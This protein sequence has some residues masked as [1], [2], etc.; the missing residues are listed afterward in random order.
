MRKNLII[1]MNLK[2]KL[3]GYVIYLHHQS[4]K[5]ALFSSTF[6]QDDEPV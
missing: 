2:N 5:Y 6:N 3:K 4:I 1:F